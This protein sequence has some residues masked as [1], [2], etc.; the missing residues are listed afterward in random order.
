M[1]LSLNTD[2]STF[3]NFFYDD[4]LVNELKEYAF[5]S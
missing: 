2:L 4:Y 1:I 3:Y 5:V